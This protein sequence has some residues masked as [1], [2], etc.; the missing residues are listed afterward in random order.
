MRA[1]GVFD[2]HESQR[3]PARRRTTA[4]RS[5]AT[6]TSTR[7]VVQ[8]VSCATA[9]IPDDGHARIRHSAWRM[10]F[11]ISLSA[12]F[13]ATLLPRW[14]ASEIATVA[15]EQKPCQA[16]QSGKRR[17]CSWLGTDFGYSI[18]QPCRAADAA[19]VA[20]AGAQESGADGFSHSPSGVP[21]RQSD[22]TWAAGKYVGRP[23]CWDVVIEPLDIRHAAPEHDD[24]RIEDVDHGSEAACHPRLV[25]LERRSRVPIA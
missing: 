1:R 21:R 4:P 23:Q 18:P 5:T 20:V 2:H 13:A 19:G 14:F 12:T 25:P 17:V 3:Q 16:H 7:R 6:I 8:L 11:A 15:I 9:T 24:V 10:P 22:R